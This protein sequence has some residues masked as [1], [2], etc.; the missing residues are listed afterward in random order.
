ML[1]LPTTDRLAAITQLDTQL[2]DDELAILNGV[3][4]GLLAKNRL[5][6]LAGGIN[7]DITAVAVA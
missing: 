1:A 4:D 3:I 6:A 5:R 7:I 2:D